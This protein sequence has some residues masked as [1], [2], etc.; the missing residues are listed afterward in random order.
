ME[1][2]VL[3]WQ[4]HYPVFLALSLLPKVLFIFTHANTTDASTE[5]VKGDDGKRASIAASSGTIL[6]TYLVH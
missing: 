6:C 1:P 5:M 2:F 4:V 3:G